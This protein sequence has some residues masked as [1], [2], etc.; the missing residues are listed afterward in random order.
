[1]GS[2]KKNKEKRKKE[3]LVSRKNDVGKQKFEK[4]DLDSVSGGAFQIKGGKV[5]NDPNG[6]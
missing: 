2:M 3:E 6:F 4:C 5:N 1:M